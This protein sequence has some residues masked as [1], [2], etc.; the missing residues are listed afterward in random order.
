MNQ[1]VKRWMANKE[2]FTKELATG[3]KW[4]LYVAE[5]LR[6]LGYCVW[7]PELEEYKK[8][9]D[10]KYAN[11]SDMLV[12]GHIVEVKS[13][14]VQFTC[15]GDFPYPTIFVKSKASY[16]AMTDKP[17]MCVVVSQ[18]T[19]E[20]CA[21]DV[22]KTYESWKPIRFYDRVRKIHTTAYE[23]ATELWE[24]L[25]TAA[26]RLIGLPGDVVDDT[27]DECK[28]DECTCGED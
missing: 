6:E 8:P 22:Q 14:N 4:E 9:H 23:C 13:R 17:V 12:G 1:E 21:L 27:A 18:L 20:M 3:H 28:C 10:P 19:G 5:R 15:P 11:S 16:D 7:V 26:E 2:L 24:P 25:E